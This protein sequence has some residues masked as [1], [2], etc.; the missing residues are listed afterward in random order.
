VPAGE[1]RGLTTISWNS[2]DGKVYVSTNGREERLFG[3]SPRG[4]QQ[5]NW[6]EAGSTYE[7]R[8]YDADHKLL[9]EKVTV[10]R[11]NE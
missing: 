5:A 7:F 6:I 9:L 8:L 11:V 2:V 1:G 4:S 3:G 10:T